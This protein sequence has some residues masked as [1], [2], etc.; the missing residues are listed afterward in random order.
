LNHRAA[1]LRLYEFR[2]RKVQAQRTYFDTG[3]LMQ[4]LGLMPEMQATTA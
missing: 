1:A 2:N 4:Q 3:S